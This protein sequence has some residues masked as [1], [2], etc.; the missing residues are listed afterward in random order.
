MSNTF[1]TKLRLF[2]KHAGIRN[3]T[4]AKA[5]NVDPA[6]VSLWLSGKRQMSR[7]NPLLAKIA[8]YIIRQC[9]SEVG[10]RW[11]ADTLEIEPINPRVDYNL[12]LGNVTDWLLLEPVHSN[13]PQETD[14]SGLF[15]QGGKV[16]MPFVGSIGLGE[17]LGMLAQQVERHAV[18]EP[19]RVYISSENCSILF[20]DRTASIWDS[21]CQL[22]PQ[23]VEV[24]FQQWE[25][26]DLTGRFLNRLM[27][28]LVRGRLKLYAL[29]SDEQYFCHNITVL[30]PGICAV[31]VLEPVA[32]YGNSVTLFVDDSGFVGPLAEVFGR[33]E[34]AAR[35]VVGLYRS[36]ARQMGELWPAFFDSGGAVDMVSDGLPLFY[37]SPPGFHRLLEEMH[38]TA[39]QRRYRSGQFALWHQRFWAGIRTGRRRELLSLDTLDSLASG[40]KIALYGASFLKKSSLSIDPD[41]ARELLSGLLQAVEECP[42][43]Q[44]RLTKCSVTD[45]YACLLRE[46]REALIYSWMGKTGCCLHTDNWLLTR[47]LRAQFSHWWESGDVGITRREHV[48]EALVYRLDKLKKPAWV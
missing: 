28:Q 22:S 29:R 8:A 6:L 23:P 35:P 31:M 44:L 7:E 39:E 18:E 12:L 45:R 3:I 48:A 14:F 38:L 41:T 24:F 34:K 25:Q 15:A 33:L 42:G 4:L 26:G 5:L 10:M 9:D 30:L 27:P 32:L 2:M 37:L 1:G 20:E 17:A 13:L 36:D 21:L 40:Q 46:D 43:Y 47:Q 11:L 19:L 16:Y